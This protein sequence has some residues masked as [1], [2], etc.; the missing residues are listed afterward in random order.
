MNWKTWL[1]LLLTLLLVAG[2]G[3]RITG[4]PPTAPT[5][6]EP[7]PMPNLLKLPTYKEAMVLKLKATQEIL[8]GIALNNPEK[9]R[10]AADSIIAVSNVADFQNRFKGQEYQ[11]H[12][13]IFRRP[14][15]AITAKAKDKNMDG[16]MIAYNELTLSCL[17]CHQAMRDNRFEVVHPRGESDR[18]ERRR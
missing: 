14:A 5:A 12:L 1:I 17:K 3:T 8:E 6:A 11:F 18:S 7:P 15:E 2:V 9:I 10:T 13:E 4:V 16:V